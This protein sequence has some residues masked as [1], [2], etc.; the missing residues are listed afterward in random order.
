MSSYLPSLLLGASLAY[1]PDLATEGPPDSPRPVSALIARPGPGPTLPVWAGRLATA[2]T[3]RAERVAVL[4][5]KEKDLDWSV[6]ESANFCVYHMQNP[7]LAE[8]VA[9]VAERARVAAQR[10]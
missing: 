8:R 7:S 4:H 10:Q 5:R 9:R 6:A 2:S 1:V 3:R